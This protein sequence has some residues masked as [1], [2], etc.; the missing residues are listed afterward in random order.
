MPKTV[1]ENWPQRQTR[2]KISAPTEKDRRDFSFSGHRSSLGGFIKIFFVCP[3]A[4]QLVIV[5]AAAAVGGIL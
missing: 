5:V 2:A 3:A 1:T 4:V